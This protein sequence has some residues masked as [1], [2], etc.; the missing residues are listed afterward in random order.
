MGTCT[1]AVSAVAT[2]ARALTGMRGA[3]VAPPDSI[4]VFP[5][6]VTYVADG[7]FDGVATSW[8]K[9]LFTVECDVHVGRDSDGARA[10]GLVE[11][12]VD[13]FSNAIEK[14]PTLTGSSDT[15][16]TFTWRLEPRTYGGV[17]TL[18]VAFRIGVKQETVIP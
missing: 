5:F 16:T 18:A 7:T 14:D 3:P 10:Y 6:A 9:H 15:I 17:Q 1:G 12:I 8:K 4:N 2:I 13:T 11:A